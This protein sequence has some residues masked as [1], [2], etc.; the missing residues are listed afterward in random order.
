MVRRRLVATAFAAVAYLVAMTAP[1]GA[2]PSSGD[3]TVSAS[4]WDFTH[5]QGE[6]QTTVT[7]YAA[8][9]TRA[10]AAAWSAQSGA[11]CAG[12]KASLTRGDSMGRGFTAHPE[13]FVC[14]LGAPP[15]SVDLG[16]GAGAYSVGITVRSNYLEFTTTQPTPLG[17]YADPRLSVAYDLTLNATIP[18][19]APNA[20]LAAT[21][22]VA[23][24]ANA[25]ADT[26]NLPAD[27]V[28]SLADV[29][30]FFGG[31]NFKTI[32]EQ[33]IDARTV[34]FTNQINTMLAKVNLPALEH[35]GFADLAAGLG[36]GAG[37][38]T[39]AL[40]L[41]RS[42]NVPTSGN[43]SVHGLV[44]WRSVYGAPAQGCG[45][46]TIAAT[47]QVGPPSQGSPTAAAG[48]PGT[49][50]GTPVVSG[51]ESQCGFTLGGLPTGVPLHLTAQVGGWGN[52]AYR[53]ISVSATGGSDVVASGPSSGN[54]RYTL[55]RIR[56]L[57]NHAVLAPGAR[58]ATTAV[59]SVALNPQPLPPGR[60]ARMAPASALG[61][62]PN[63][64]VFEVHLMDAHP[65]VVPTP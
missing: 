34:D 2:S 38:A 7:P 53:V 16:L 63:G 65:H 22:A 26:H 46:F 57:P 52:A 45:A 36:N 59:R 10:V 48:S 27:I 30:R 11:I 24:V 49:A 12:I 9:L 44:Q 29:V 28:A 51:Q 60:V 1:A 43:G 54:G 18:L 42:A 55:A 58:S 31:P 64:V 39:M 33:K 6:P 41:Q 4:T 3:V 62:V 61:V 25:H 20:P 15:S 21:S 14:N 19:P 23:H 13:N 47:V 40:S 37:G 32:A 56:T 50:L 8:L 5:P 17:S 35:Q